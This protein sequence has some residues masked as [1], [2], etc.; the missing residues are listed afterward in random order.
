MAKKGTEPA[1]PAISTIPLA[2]QDSPLVIDLPDGQKLVVGN[3]AHGTVIEVATWRGTGRP[4][5]RT[6]R[7]ML[8]VSSQSTATTQS[9]SED[10]TASSEKVE[11][12]QTFWKRLI[13]SLIESSPKT[14]REK[15]RKKIDE[16]FDEDPSSLDPTSAEIKSPSRVSQALDDPNQIEKWLDELIGDSSREFERKGDSPKIKRVSTSRTRERSSSPSRSSKST[17]KTAHAR[18]RRPSKTASKSSK[19]R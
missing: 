14:K 4:D 12:K 17:R 13:G 16:I 2:D 10:A 3:M 11:V 1:A 7:L 19:K 15:K 8:G 9:S 5:S 18:V 6:S